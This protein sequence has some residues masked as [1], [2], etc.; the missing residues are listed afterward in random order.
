[1]KATHSGAPHDFN[2]FTVEVTVPKFLVKTPLRKDGQDFGPGDTV[3]LSK[4]QADGIG[5]DVLDPIN[6]TKE[7]GTGAKT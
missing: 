3:E 7:N 5:S 2:D 4:K 6:D 1:M